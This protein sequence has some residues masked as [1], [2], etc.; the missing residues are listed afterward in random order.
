MDKNGFNSIADSRILRFAVDDDAV[1]HSRIGGLIDEDM[2][3]TVRMPQH[4]DECVVLDVLY[5][6]VRSSRD[7]QV[8][9][10]IHIQQSPYG[11]ST[12][13]TTDRVGG[14]AAA[15]RECSTHRFEDGAHGVF[16]FAASLEN[17]GVT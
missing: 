9:Q 17:Y 16:H 7:N 8:D 5:E 3:D 10:A 14:N 2:A 15:Q 1:D 13:D 6:R 11:F 4:R 12:V